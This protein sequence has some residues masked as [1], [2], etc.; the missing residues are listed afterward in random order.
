MNADTLLPLIAA[1]AAL[2]L[3]D[4]AAVAFG[5]DDDHDAGSGAAY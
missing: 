4:L 1:I 5:A 3:L 2:V